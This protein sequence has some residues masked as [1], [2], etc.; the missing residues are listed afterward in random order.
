MPPAGD[1]VTGSG[2]GVGSHT[3]PRVGWG[4]KQ[5]AELG[6]AAKRP[7]PSTQAPEHCLAPISGQAPHALN[8]LL[9]CTRLRPILKAESTE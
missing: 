6:T 8:I 3:D 1:E 5:H 2:V 9:N 4:G 7:N